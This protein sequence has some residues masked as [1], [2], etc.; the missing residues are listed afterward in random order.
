MVI[1]V[2]PKQTGGNGARFIKKPHLLPNKVPDAVHNVFLVKSPRHSERGGI[3]TVRDEHVRKRARART[4]TST[5]STCVPSR[6]VPQLEK[7]VR[8][9][10]CALCV[11]GVRVARV[12]TTRARSVQ[13][14]I[15]C[16]HVGCACARVGGTQR[17]THLEG[18]LVID[19]IR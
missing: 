8:V 3:R 5:E 19:Q 1:K 16:V 2:V 12:R 4:K 13:M 6:V 18:G 17:L 15:M 9:I 7:R 11:K 14:G 10:T